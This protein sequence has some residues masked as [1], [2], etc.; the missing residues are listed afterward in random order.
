[1]SSLT[2][3]CTSPPF[4]PHP[5]QQV[6]MSL[7]TLL[8]SMVTRTGSDYSDYYSDCIGDFVAIIKFLESCFLRPP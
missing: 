6:S 4:P 7:L 8:A 3:D 2:A 1:M 5:A